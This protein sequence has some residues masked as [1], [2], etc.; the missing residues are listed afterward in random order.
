[1]GVR[2]PSR[3]LASVLAPLA[4]VACGGLPGLGGCD[5]PITYVDLVDRAADEGSGVERAELERAARAV[6]DGLPGFSFRSARGGEVGWQLTLAI[7]Q[8]TDHATTPGAPGRTRSVG[9]SLALFPLEAGREERV[10]VEQLTT[11]EVQA[12]AP[13]APLVRAAIEAAGAKLAAAV[14]LT[15]GDDDAVLAAL[16][17][18]D[19]EVRARAV[20]LA[21]SR[22]I[23]AAA[24]PI[25]AMLAAP[26]VDDG[27]LLQVGGALASIGDPAA[28]GPM[29]DALRGRP[30][31][32]VGAMLHALGALGGREAEAYLITV[33]EGHPEPSLREIARQALRARA[34]SGAGSAP[35]P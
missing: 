1:V 32:V 24:A 10:D 11:A 28:A 13:W 18:S 7:E 19:A 16:G 2:W 25:A 8:R 12:G 31:A 22:R 21:G 35:R 29:I 9:V 14:V 27:T 4:L 15:R 17:S 30:P 33:R 6:I 23:R 3:R 20:Q 34:A 5:R 26:G